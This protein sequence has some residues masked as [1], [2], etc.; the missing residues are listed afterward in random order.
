MLGSADLQDWADEGDLV[1]AEK[2]A[3]YPLRRFGTAAVPYPP[4]ACET[5][6]ETRFVQSGLA[7]TRFGRVLTPL[8]DLC[9]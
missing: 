3:R 2:M 1:R 5:F 4:I 7:V 6:R 8:Q 9:E